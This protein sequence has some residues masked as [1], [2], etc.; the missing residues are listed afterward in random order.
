MLLRQSKFKG[1]ADYNNIKQLAKD[2]KGDDPHGDRAELIQLIEK[3]ALYE[4]TATAEK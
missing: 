1:A 4:A 2:S 3:A